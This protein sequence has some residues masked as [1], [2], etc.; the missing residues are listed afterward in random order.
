M[1]LFKREEYLKKISGFI[2]KPVIKVITGLRRSGKSSFLKLLIAKLSHK[3]SIYINKEDTDFDFIKNYQDLDLYIKQVTS[4]SKDK[5]Y[6]FIDEVQEIDGWE[7]SIRSI[8]SKNKLDI[9]ITGSNAN[10]LSSELAT[11]ISGRYIEFQI[12]PLSFM[13]FLEFRRENKSDDIKKEFQLYM[14]YG[15][16]PGIHNLEFDDTLIYQ[17]VR[18][19]YTTVLLKDIIARYEIRNFQLLE[20]IVKFAFVNIGNSFSAKSISDYLKSQKLSPGVDTVQNYLGFL[21]STYMLNK[22]SRYDLKGKRVLEINDKYFLSDVGIRHSV[23][24]FRES[25]ISGILENIVYIELRRRGYEVYVG[26]YDAY[27]IDF[28]AT[29]E[30]EKKYFQ[31]CTSLSSK[32]TVEREFRSLIKINDNYPKYVLSLDEYWGNDYQGINRLNL[33]EFLKF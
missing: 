30:N 27:E 1:K 31:V 28:I 26:K 11:F 13:E 21:C 7:K 22:V 12:Y 14:K 8:L 18:S 25:D 15:S 2:N 32:E 19:I 6:L 17:F 3:K 24:G 4:K 33:L 10:L 9:Y 29:K 20:N 5:K 23:L 16:L